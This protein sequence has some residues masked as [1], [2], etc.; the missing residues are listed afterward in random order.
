M[1]PWIACVLFVAAPLAAESFPGVADTPFAQEY[2]TE[3]AYPAGA[4]ARQVRALAVTPDGVVWLA[5]KAGVYC[6]SA[7]LWKQVHSGSTY[8]LAAQGGG[9]WAGAWDGLYRIRD[10]QAER[11]GQIGGPVVALWAG[12]GKVIAA[13]QERFWESNGQEWTSRPWTGARGVRAIARDARGGL[14]VA[15]RMGGYYVAPDGA[16][17]EFHDESELLSGELSSVKI[18]PDGSVWL[19]SD[20]GVDVY[21]DGW[22]EAHFNAASGMPNQ[23]VQALEIAADGTVWMGTRLGALRRGNGKWS[24]R[25]S[26]RWLPSDSVV[27]MAA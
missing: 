24:L 14:W 21:R 27:A 7:G 8:T 4:N 3:V 12:N 17:R 13:G 6:Y 25:H 15:T 26:R 20:G 19:G 18:A 9:V 2:R 5:A 1:R 22:R 16:R 23:E 10:G 11:I